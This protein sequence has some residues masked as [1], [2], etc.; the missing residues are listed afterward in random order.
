MPFSAGARC[1]G[2][3]WAPQEGPAKGLCGAARH[4]AHAPLTGLRSISESTLSFCNLH[5]AACS[6]CRRQPCPRP[7][8]LGVDLN[9]LVKCCPHSWATCS[10]SIF[11]GCGRGREARPQSCGLSQQSRK[12][13]SSFPFSAP[14]RKNFN[15]AFRPHSLTRNLAQHAFLSPPQCLVI[16][17]IEEITANLYPYPTNKTIGTKPPPCRLSFHKHGEPAWG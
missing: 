9:S 1:R 10:S 11:R 7:D 17:G 3:A 14:L 8:V 12:A 4:A 2:A 5:R 6:V 16:H 13:P 15:S